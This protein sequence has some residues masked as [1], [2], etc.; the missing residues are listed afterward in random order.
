MTTV[1]Y[2]D[3]TPKN[4]IETIVSIFFTIISSIVFAFTLNS[5][6]DI[7]DGLR[8]QE[9]IEEDLMIKLNKYLK[10]KNISDNLSYGI[11]EH[12]EYYFKQSLQTQK[13]TEAAI[14]EILSDTLKQ[15]LLME[16]YKVALQDS[17]IFKRNF[18]EDVNFV[19]FIY[20]NW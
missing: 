5:I 2:G 1:G 18:S 14:F 13:E 20:N 4:Y 11:R 8:G 19:Y 10:D 15:K 7:I 9:K 12:V 16:S 6:G 17:P 3:I